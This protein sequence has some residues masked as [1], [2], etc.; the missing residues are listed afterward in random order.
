MWSDKPR[1]TNPP[2]GSPAPAP[3]SQRAVQPL[4]GTPTA[5]AHA[6]APAV[7][8]LAWLGPSLTVLG[9]ISGNEDLQIEGKV[10]GRIALGGH[11][12]IVGPKAET[13]DEIV[14]R[15]LVIH[16]KAHGDLRARDRLEIKKN[17]DVKGDLTTARLIIEDG[18]C[19]K[20]H[21]EIDRG[22]ASVGT[23]LDGL[24]ARSTTKPK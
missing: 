22:H 16:G 6:P 1:Q 21:I 24:L 11:R 2:G 8:P 10:E 19:F 12:V 7:R 4:P 14:A 3:Q 17:A 9:Q 5:S 15:E 13:G 20:G 23:D 18:A